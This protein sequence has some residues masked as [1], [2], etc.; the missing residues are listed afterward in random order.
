ML[1]HLKCSIPKAFFRIK[2][3]IRPIKWYKFSK[4]VCSSELS[5]CSLRSLENQ[6]NSAAKKMKKSERPCLLTS[7]VNE[8]EW[9]NLRSVF[10]TARSEYQ[11]AFNNAFDNYRIG[12]EDAIKND[13][14]AFFKYVK[15]AMNLEATT[16]ST[17][18]GKCELFADFLRRSYID[19]T[20]I[21]SDPVPAVVSNT[22][23]PGSI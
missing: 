16:A 7:N 1:E 22:P 4:F 13:P 6:I 10:T 19:D 21:A 2:A 15:Y 11:W 14:K 12:I 5:C 18:E 17:N 23:P 3:K 9:E 20:W 8:C